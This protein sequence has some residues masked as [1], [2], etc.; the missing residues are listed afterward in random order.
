MLT[1]KKTNYQGSTIVC[2]PGENSCSSGAV[3]KAAESQRH[4]RPSQSLQRIVASRSTAHL[5]IRATSPTHYHT[6][7]DVVQLTGGVA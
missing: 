7:C 6:W 2:G 5:L 1:N 3:F 4:R